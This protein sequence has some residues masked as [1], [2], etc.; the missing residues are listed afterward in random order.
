MHSLVAALGGSL[1]WCLAGCESQGDER[2]EATTA[3]TL[4]VAEPL[5]EIEDDTPPFLVD[6]SRADARVLGI[7][8]VDLMDYTGRDSP[9]RFLRHGEDEPFSLPLDPTSRRNTTTVREILN[10]R[11]AEAWFELSRDRMKAV[12]EAAAD[13][14]ERPGELALDRLSHMLGDRVGFKSD[15]GLPSWVSER[16]I[17]TWLPGYSRDGRLALVRFVVP[18]KHH[19]ISTYLLEREG[20]AWTVLLRDFV[21]YH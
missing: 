17:F 21:S 6:V 9:L 19:P 12:E 5:P 8:F 10:P 13:F 7:V 14:T 20:D 11:R 18:G 15:G 16:P 2:V 3:E 4:P 1:A